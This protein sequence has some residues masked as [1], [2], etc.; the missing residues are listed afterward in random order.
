MLSSKFTIFNEKI[1]V[2]LDPNSPMIEIF[3]YSQMA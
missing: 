1:E 2:D 3:I